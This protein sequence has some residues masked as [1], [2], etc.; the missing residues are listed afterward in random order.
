MVYFIVL[1]WHIGTTGWDIKVNEDI[2]LLVVKSTD[3][4]NFAIGLVFG[5]PNQDSAEAGC[6]I[7]KTDLDIKTK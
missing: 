1:K 5:F 3:I 7:F 6:A 2:Y 4:D